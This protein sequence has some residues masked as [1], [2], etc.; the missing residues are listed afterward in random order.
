MYHVGSV[1]PPELAPGIRTYASLG[2]RFGLYGRKSF[3][4]V[5]W[6]YL[7]VTLYYNR[8]F[9]QFLAFRQ[10]FPNDRQFEDLDFFVAPTPN[11]FSL[12]FSTDLTIA[13]DPEKSKQ[14]QLH[15]AFAR[16]FFDQYELVLDD[17]NI[18]DQMHGSILFA[19]KGF[20]F[21]VSVGF[22][23]ARDYLSFISPI[24]LGF[25]HHFN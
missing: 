17:G 6:S 15:F 7:G 1:L 12:A 4:K 16:S 21:R 11:L 8:E 22:L 18:I 19:G 23:F 2:G 20:G 3:E 13:L 25:F 10:N 5:D 14:L 9:G 24:G